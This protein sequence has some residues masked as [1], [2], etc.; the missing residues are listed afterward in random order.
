MVACCKIA[1]HDNIAAQAVAVVVDTLGVVKVGI[2]HTLMFHKLTILEIGSVPVEGYIRAFVIG[3]HGRI[4]ATQEKFIKLA[5]GINTTDGIVCIEAETWRAFTRLDFLRHLEGNAELASFHTNLPLIEHILIIIHFPCAVI[6][7][8]HHQF[9]FLVV[10]PY[11]Q[12][13]V[14]SR[15]ELSVDIPYFALQSHHA[16]G[17]KSE[18]DGRACSD[19]IDSRYSDVL[20]RQR[21]TQHRVT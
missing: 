15:I 17:M 10:E 21:K 3:H 6:S 20:L 8:L 4:G 5:R 12:C 11:P 16:H 1:V 14:E 7:K 13:A 18:F 2:K 9:C 19:S